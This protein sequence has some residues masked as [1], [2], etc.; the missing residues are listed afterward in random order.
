MRASARE[1]ADMVNSQF[2][3]DA[4]VDKYIDSSRQRLYNIL[5]G[6]FESYFI[7]W[8][9]QAALLPISAGAAGLKVGEADY[10][11]PADY[12]K[13]VLVERDYSGSSSELNRY[14]WA[15]VPRYR[16]LSNGAPTGYV[17][18]GSNDY[19]PQ[20]TGAAVSGSR[21]RLLPAPDVTTYNLTFTYVPACPLLVADTGPTGSMDHIN[22]FNDWVELDVVIK[23][24]TKEE[25]DVRGLVAERGQWMD[26]MEAVFI[27]RD[28]GQPST[29]MGDLFNTGIDDGYE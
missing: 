10:M 24:L 14:R 26:A 15:E 17:L 8:V 19:D 3:T 21:I 29:A 22:G 20:S 13:M 2:V 11:L 4:E 23:M 5:V 25:A 16:G 1:R 12:Y 28:I 6:K 18:Y 27:P 9:T 7:K